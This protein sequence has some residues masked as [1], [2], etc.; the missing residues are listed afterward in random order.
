MYIEMEAVSDFRVIADYPNYIINSSGIVI[1]VKRQKF[2]HGGISKLGYRYVTLSNEHGARSFRIHRLIYE[3]FVG[4][5]TDGFVID[6]KNNNRLD[7]RLENL[8]MVT[9]SYNMKKDYQERSRIPRPVRAICVNNGKIL[10]FKSQ[11]NAG[12]MLGINPGGI[13]FCCD[14]TSNSCR[15]KTSGLWYRF[16]YA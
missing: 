12:R 11:S 4:N 1:N 15:S 9:Q 14:G 3:T 2:I 8:Q 10:M 5:I 6:H 16:E 7:N 13:K